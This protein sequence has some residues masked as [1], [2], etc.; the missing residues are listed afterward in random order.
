MK[1]VMLISQSEAG[2]LL[3]LT[4]AAVAYNARVR[5]LLTPHRRKGRLLYDIAEIQ[6]FAQQRGRKT[7]R[8]S[9][10]DLLQRRF[11]RGLRD[12]RSARW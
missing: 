7:G 5:R 3:G 8:P 11:N 12:N 9:G 1:N 10:K 2:A 4:P 6:A